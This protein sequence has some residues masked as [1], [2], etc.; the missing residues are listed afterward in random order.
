MIGRLSLRARLLLGVLGLAMI[1]LLAADLATYKS[2]QSFLLT[3]TDRSLNSAHLTIEQGAAP[4][5]VAAAAPGVYVARLDLTGTVLASAGPLD[6]PP[7]HNRPSPP[8]LPSTIQLPG[9][10]SGP[11][12]VRYFTV[13]ALDGGSHFRVRASNEN[14]TSD[15]LVVAL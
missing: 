2:L 10:S 11:E 8:R 3:R 12:R 13:S 7:R 4:S 1:G 14:G 15:I 5:T 9:S 6:F